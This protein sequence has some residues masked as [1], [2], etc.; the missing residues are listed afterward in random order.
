MYVSQDSQL[1]Q[2][3]NLKPELTE[4]LAYILPD[5]LEVPSQRLWTLDLSIYL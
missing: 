4:L 5:S 1:A 2:E 3:G